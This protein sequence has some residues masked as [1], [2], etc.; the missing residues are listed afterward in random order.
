MAV[1]RRRRGNGSAAPIPG[2]RLQSTSVGEPGTFSAGPADGGAPIHPEPCHARGV[3][4]GWPGRES[5]QTMSGREPAAGSV[6]E[7]R[8]RRVYEPATAEDGRRILVERLW[9]RGLTKGKARV[10]A[11]LK[12][13]APSTELRRWYGH[14]PDKWSEFRRRYREELNAHPKVLAPLL[15]AVRSGPV[16]LVYA[17]RDE[18]HTSALVLRDVLDERLRSGVFDPD[19]LVDEASA[20]SFPASDAPAWAIGRAYPSPAESD[21]P[22]S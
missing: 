5:E 18:R 10:D 6:P 11:W 13:V 8:L 14:D 16:T 15:D 22:T 3:R 12:D 20:E 2:S 21:T 1:G 7:I 9:P 17:A 19:A 4:T